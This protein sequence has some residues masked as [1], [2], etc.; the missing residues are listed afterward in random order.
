MSDSYQP[1]YD[2]VRSKLGGCDMG[3]AIQSAIGNA[4]ISH[5]FQQ[6]LQSFQQAAWEY[7]RPSVVFKPTLSQDGDSWIALLGENIQE[8]VV[9]CGSTPAKAMYDFDRA[10]V[11]E[12]K[13]TPTA[14]QIM[15]LHDKTMETLKS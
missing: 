8:G 11:T 1:I 3:D 14:A 5:Y 13:P 6:A 15:E 7:E 9:G 10:W 12:T 2:A 4:N